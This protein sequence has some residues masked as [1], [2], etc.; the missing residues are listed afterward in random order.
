MSDY[1]LPLLSACPNTEDNETSTALAEESL[2][3]LIMKVQKQLIQL[4]GQFELYELDQLHLSKFETE[5]SRSVTFLDVIEV[6]KR[7]VDILFIHVNM[8]TNDLYEASHYDANQN[9]QNVQTTISRLEKE[10]HIV[11]KVNKEQ[12]KVAKELEQQIRD[13]KDDAGLKKSVT[14]VSSI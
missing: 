10:I 8:L 1:L 13:L 2:K 11:M 12:S 6:I 5:I 3:D 14:E 4:I 9:K 7:M